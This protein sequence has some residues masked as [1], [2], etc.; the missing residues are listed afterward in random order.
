L[1]AARTLKRDL[2]GLVRTADRNGTRVVVRDAGA[3]AFGLGWLARTLLRREASALRALAGLNAVPALIAAGRDVAIREYVIG[4]PLQVARCRDPGFYREAARVL[5]SMHRRNV[6]HN[7]LAKEPNLLVTPAGS[8]V[9]IDFQLAVVAKRRHK[10]FRI[11]A[12]ED[13]RH[14]LKHKRTY[15]PDALTQRERRLLAS[16]SLPSLW[17][18]R[19][20]KPV[21]LFITR[22]ILG[23]SD[24]EGAGDRSLRR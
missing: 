9:F 12:R 8:P 6:V 1:E 7:D 3:A 10:L 17:F 15:C 20:V 24:R 21:Y 11:L 4:D 18:R 5:R 14:L 2:F 22:R 13:I 19:T 23:W 16:P